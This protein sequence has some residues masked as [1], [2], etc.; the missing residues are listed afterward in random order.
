MGVSSAT[1]DA[2]NKCDVMNIY[3]SKTALN[4]NRLIRLS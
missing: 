2:A 4:T 3:Q 1:A